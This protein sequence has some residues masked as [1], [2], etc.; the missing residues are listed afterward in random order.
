MANWKNIFLSRINIYLFLS[1]L[2]S[3]GYMLLCLLLVMHVNVNFVLVQSTMK[4]NAWRLMC[5][6]KFYSLIKMWHSYWKTYFKLLEFSVHNS[7]LSICNMILHQLNIKVVVIQEFMLIWKFYVCA[8]SCHFWFWHVGINLDSY[9]GN[10]SL[11]LSA[12]ISLQNKTMSAAEYLWILQNSR[13]S[14]LLFVLKSKC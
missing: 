12:A 5:D 7:W 10:K 2:I 8:S 3:L 9:L 4:L 6:I 11:I 1:Y 14:S 13:I